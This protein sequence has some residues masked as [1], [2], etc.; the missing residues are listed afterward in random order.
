MPTNVIRSEDGGRIR[1]GVVRDEHVAVLDGEY[2]TTSDFLQH[3]AD[4]ARAQSGKATARLRPLADLSILSPVTRN[5]QF[6]RQFT[7]YRSHIIEGGRRPDEVTSPDIAGGIETNALASLVDIAPT[8]MDLTGVD[9]DSLRR[10]YPPFP[11][12]DLSRALGAGAARDFAAGG[13]TALFGAVDVAHSPVHRRR[14]RSGQSP[15][16]QGPAR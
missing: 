10:V 15:K 9:G 8:L 1:W 5:Q 16:Q 3:E 6:I 12:V 7:N 4:A 13:R 14:P 2:A 11:G